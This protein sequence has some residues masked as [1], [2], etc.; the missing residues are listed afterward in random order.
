MRDG[1]RKKFRPLGV[2]ILINEDA[3]DTLKPGTDGEDRI[4]RGINLDGCYIHDVDGDENYNTNKLSGGVGI[5]I[6]Y[7]NS[8]NRYPVF[9][10]VTVQNNRIDQVDRCGIKAIRLTVPA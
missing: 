5:E 10:G 8:N 3:A 2:H 9:D 7:H 6:K 4:Y 1:G